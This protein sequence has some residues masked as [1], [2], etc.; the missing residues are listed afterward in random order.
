MLDTPFPVPVTE[1][2]AAPAPVRRPWWDR[3]GRP[4]WLRRAGAAADALTDLLLLVALTATTPVADL[5]QRLGVL[6]VGAVLVTGVVRGLYHPDPRTSPFDRGIVLSEVLIVAVAMVVVAGAA[7]GIPWSPGSLLGAWAIAGMALLVKRWVVNLIDVAAWRRG[8]GVSRVLFAGAEGESG[9]RLMQAVVNDPRLG[10]RL[11]GYLSTDGRGTDLP[12]ATER[13]IA[14]A[15]H[16]GDL[17]DLVAVARRVRA[18]EVIFVLGERDLPRLGHYV[19]LARGAGL[20]VRI[21][22]VLGEAG[23]ATAVRTVAGVPLISF[24]HEVM[25]RRG[26][27][28]KRS[29]DLLVAG[30]ALGLLAMPMALIALVIRLDSAGP[31]ILRQPR[32]GRHG[33]QFDALKFRTMVDGADRLRDDLIAE[34]GATDARLFK[35]AADPRLTRAGK[36]LRRWSLD[37]LPQLWNIVRGEMSVVGPRPPLPDE[38]ALY[39]PVHLQ[40]LAVVPGLT[41]LWQVNGRSDL[42]FE[43]MIRLDLY[44]VETWSPWLDLKLMVRTIPAVLGGRGA[45]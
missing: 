25:S 33:R 44:Y 32:V 16:L 23:G 2:A 17:R 7:L 12:V 28:F 40:R 4:P 20:A 45:Y 26:S 39:A 9:R 41:G 27:A 13:R 30:I 43:E 31:V 24:D 6:L 34:T 35:H 42:N 18:D 3:H 8:I 10:G 22:P 5:D 38:V 11:V 21:A 15:R 37:E 36:W 29:M 1:V 19:D 14:S